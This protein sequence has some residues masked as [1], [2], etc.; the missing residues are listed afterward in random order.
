[1]SSNRL[2]ICYLCPQTLL[3]VPLWSYTA[4][5][6]RSFWKNIYFFL[7]SDA[8]W[9]S[10]FLVRYPLWS[11]NIPVNKPIY[12]LYVFVSF[13]PQDQIGFSGIKFTDVEVLPCISLPPTFVMPVF[14][15]SETSLHPSSFLRL[16]SRPASVTLFTRG[17]DENPLSSPNPS[18]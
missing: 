12:R 1:M 6:P 15:P 11:R 5:I 16:F 4:D 9:S 8:V 3:A 10:F 13:D 14:F 18:I 7:F 17:R 2:F